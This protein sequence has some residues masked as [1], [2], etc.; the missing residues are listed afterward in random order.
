[1]PAWVWASTVLPAHM[2]F[3]VK[4]SIR[5]PD[6]GDRNG[7]GMQ[8]RALTSKQHTILGFVMA[9]LAGR[10]LREFLRKPVCRNSNGWCRSACKGAGSRSQWKLA[11]CWSRG[12]SRLLWK[13][14]S[15]KRQE[16]PNPL[17]M[18][19]LHNLRLS[20]DAA[21]LFI[22]PVFMV[23]GFLQGR[24]MHKTVSHHW[25]QTGLQQMSLHLPKD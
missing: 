21:L 9:I 1:M 20:P 22:K 7:R 12:P 24:S 10:G 4:I 23:A 2:L 15:G 14:Y 5:S 11:R 8:P 18:S 19:V 3:F 17:E 16:R 6:F 13:S 25:C